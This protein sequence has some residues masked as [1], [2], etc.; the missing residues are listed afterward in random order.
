MI[1]DLD[2]DVIAGKNAGMDGVLIDAENYYRDLEVTHRV[3]DIK[4]IEQIIFE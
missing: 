1:G 3:R 4:E 2:I